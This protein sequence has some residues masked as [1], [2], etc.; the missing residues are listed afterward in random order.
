MLFY[1]YLASIA[2]SVAIIYITM[3]SFLG[4]LKKDHIE[5]IGKFSRLE[6]IKFHGLLILKILVPLF[7]LVYIL[8]LLC[9]QS[10][11]YQKLVTKLFL[12][13]KAIF[14]NDLS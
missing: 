10:Y 2:V 9:W 11:L 12:D 5:I 3:V 7:N 6:E 8:Y 13:G 1:L 4:K 14:L